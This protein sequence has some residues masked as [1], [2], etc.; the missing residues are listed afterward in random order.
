MDREASFTRLR[1]YCSSTDRL[2]NQPLYQAVARMARDT[3]LYGATVLR[4]VMGVGASSVIHSSKLWE[5]AEK[6]PM[7]IEV[8]DTEEKILS[9]FNGLKPLLEAQPKGVLVTSEPVQVELQKHGKAGSSE[10]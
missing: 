9:F 3:G 5:I 10:G 8:V 4:G 6:L 7:V 1:L 2:G